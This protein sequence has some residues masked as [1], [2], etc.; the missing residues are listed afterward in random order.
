M[1]KKRLL[2]TPMGAVVQN[3]LNTRSELWLKA[4]KANRSDNC[5][6]NQADYDDRLYQEFGRLKMRD[7]VGFPAQY[8]FWMC[9]AN[10]PKVEDGMLTSDELVPPFL[11]M[12]TWV[13][14]DQQVKKFWKDSNHYDYFTREVLGWG[15]NSWIKAIEKAREACDIKIKAKKVP[16]AKSGKTSGDLAKYNLEARSDLWLQASKIYRS[17]IVGIDYD[18]VHDGTFENLKMCEIN[19]L[20]GRY[21]FWTC[22]V[23]TPNTPI[24]GRVTTSDE[25]VSPTFADEPSCLYSQ[26]VQ[27]FWEGSEQSDYFITPVAEWIDISWNEAIGNARQAYDMKIKAKKVPKQKTS[28]ESK[29]P[30]RGKRTPV[31]EQLDVSKPPQVEDST[32]V[33][34]QLKKR[35]LELEEEVLKL[36]KLKTEGIDPVV[37]TKDNSLLIQSKIEEY[38]SDMGGKLVLIFIMNDG[39]PPSVV[40]IAACVATVLAD[41]TV[42]QKTMKEKAKQLTQRVLLS[43]RGN[44]PNWA[45]EYFY[46]H[47]WNPKKD[48]KI[49]ICARYAVRGPKKITMNVFSA[50]K[51]RVCDKLCRVQTDL[52]LQYFA[53]EEMEELYKNGKVDNSDATI[54]NFLSKKGVFVGRVGATVE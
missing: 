41:G 50:R 8:I 54:L 40:C 6:Y 38:L 48:D 20:S 5:W 19:S 29:K 28:V 32:E 18:P 17:S 46:D 31:A 9:L 37:D 44:N 25:L 13:T 39:P 33:I 3:Y 24:Y 14:H 23:N 35:I 21:I 11:V 27:K 51:N 36:K 49:W 7:I 47:Y 34:N 2:Y 22:L 45:I 42:C 43:G 52:E 15:E 12:E 16:K 53:P 30:P 26:H 10:T 1:Q 4:T